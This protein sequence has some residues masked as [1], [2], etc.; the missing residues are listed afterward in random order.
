MFQI[1]KDYNVVS[2][3]KILSNIIEIKVFFIIKII[4]LYLI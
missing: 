2:F 1:V 3:L 4:F